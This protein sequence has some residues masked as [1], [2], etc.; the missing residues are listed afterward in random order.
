MEILLTQASIGF[1]QF[2]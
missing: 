2:E 1:I